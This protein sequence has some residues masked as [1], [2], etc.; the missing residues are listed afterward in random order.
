[1]LIKALCD[2]YDKVMVPNGEDAPKGY[3]KIQ[4][5]HTIYLNP[6]GTVDSIVAYKRDEK[7]KIVEK[8]II[9]P[10]RREKTCTN[11]E[12]IEHRGKY[13]FGL[14]LKNGKFCLNNKCHESFKNRN[15]EFIEGICSDIVNAYRNFILN[16][17]PENEIKNNHLLAICKDYNTAKFE[18]RMGSNL[19]IAL[20][21]DKQVKDKWDSE[22]D[23]WLSSKKDDSTVSQCAIYGEN[24]T[25]AR[26]HKKIKGIKS[27]KSTG[28]VLV[29][30]NED[31]EC[32]YGREQSYN[33]NIS[34]DA[35]EKYTDALNYILNTKNNKMNL[36]DITVAYWAVDKENKCE[37]LFAEFFNK[38]SDK[39]D[40]AGTEDIL[41]KLIS[42]AKNGGLLESQIS[43]LNDIDPNVDFY[44]VGLK[45]NAARLAVKFIYHRKYGQILQNIA[46]HQSDLQINEDIDEIVTISEIQEAI[47][48]FKQKENAKGKKEKKEEEIVNP[49]IVTKIFKSI[50]YGYRYPEALL[51]ATLNR[52]KI[53]ASK[54]D[55][56]EDV[57]NKKLRKS[58]C[59]LQAGIIKACINRKSLNGEELKMSLD[60]NN[61]N[62]AYI[63]GRLFAV[64]EKIQQGSAGNG[65][66]RTIKNSYFSS[67]CSRPASVFPQI[68]KL[69]QCH[70]EKLEDEGFKIHY[71][72]L[73]GT[74]ID[75]LAGS[76]PKHFSLDDQG[77]FII[78]YYH[79][80]QDLYKSKKEQNY[81]EE[82]I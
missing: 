45:P 28:E 1:M 78:G 7:G 3:S 32:S 77:R 17:K 74:I 26:T 66:N 13:I 76:F 41:R 70:L 18:F 43:D 2:Y 50:I 31:A 47:N 81:N 40:A 14:E 25:I 44:I 36:G 68:L 38:K 51:S 63:C 53:D 34:D 39:E 19:E 20:H 35:M 60:E 24:K 62:S 21:D 59:R 75:R 11:S 8:P 6:D 33:S 52:F 64:L 65:L 5:T 55:S 54:V 82:E 16:W 10:R 71:K 69:S 49:E 58:R 61:Q 57:K 56:E 80:V 9:V 29:S 48:P 22:K 23:K 30:F 27:G 37:D 12:I 46:K 79:Q 72:K 73:I 4:I 15:L 67:A 42:S